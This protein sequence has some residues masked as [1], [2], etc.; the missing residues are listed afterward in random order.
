[1][2]NIK[3]TKDFIENN[4]TII[5]SL[6]DDFRVVDPISKKV[7][8]NTEGTFVESEGSCFSS[9]NRNKICDN[10]IS[11]RALSNKSTYFKIENIGEK[12]YIITAVPLDIEDRTIVV[13]LIKDITNSFCYE[14]ATNKENTR[15]HKMFDEMRKI[16]NEDSLTEIY[17]RR[18]IDERLPIDM[19]KCIDNN[20][21][22]S[23][24]MSDV[25]YYKDINDKYGHLTGDVVLKKFAKYLKKCI[26]TNKDW[27]ARYGGDEFLICIPE[28]DEKLAFEVAERMHH[29]INDKGIHFMNKELKITASFGICTIY[30]KNITMEEFINRADRKLYLAK[31]SGRNK[32]AF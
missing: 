23:I 4:P 11:I 6:Y 8:L 25:D 28:A 24:I 15:V 7:L 20:K 9:M 18:Y 14:D 10:C 30:D 27:I 2:K 32:I 16:V 5:K 29:Y 21:P 1:M 31:S 26:R 17:N 12:V 19:L 3:I 22:I 13:E